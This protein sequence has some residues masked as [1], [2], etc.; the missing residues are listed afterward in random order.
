MPWVWGVSIRGAAHE[1][2]SGVQEIERLSAGQVASFHQRGGRAE[3]EDDARE[4][5]LSE[6]GYLAPATSLKMGM[7]ASVAR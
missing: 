4:L 5:S 3:V 2:G 6:N 1:L 7:F